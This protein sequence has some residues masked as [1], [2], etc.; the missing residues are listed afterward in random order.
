MRADGGGVPFCPATRCAM[1]CGFCGATEK[2]WMKKRSHRFSTIPNARS[3]VQK[4]GT[5]RSM[6]A[7]QACRSDLMT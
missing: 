1:A 6:P 7:K 3:A 2:R 4:S 5:M